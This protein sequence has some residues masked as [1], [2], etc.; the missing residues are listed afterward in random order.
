MFRKKKCR[1]K[2]L[3]WCCQTW[4]ILQSIYNN[5]FLNLFAKSVYSTVLYPDALIGS[6][7]APEHTSPCEQWVQTYFSYFSH[8]LCPGTGLSDLKGPF[9]ELY[10]SCQSQARSF[11]WLEH[12][13]DRCGMMGEWWYI[14]QTLGQNKG[15]E[16]SLCWGNSVG[17][18]PCAT[19]TCPKFKPLWEFHFKQEGNAEINVLV[20]VLNTIL[21]VT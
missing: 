2:L 14:R 17:D 11:Y 5:P 13:A 21:P 3:G 8:L 6:H 16:V 9:S 19:Y 1:G 4:Q 7:L 12:K 20:M 10:M 18:C 15:T